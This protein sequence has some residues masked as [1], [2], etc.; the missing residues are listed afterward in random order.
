MGQSILETEPPK[1]DRRV[2]YG[3]GA[4]HFAD[5]R[6][7]AGPKP[8]PVV[9]NIHGG[10]WRARYDLTHAGHFCAALTT[11]GIATCNLEYRR[12]GNPG[13]GW[14]GTLDDI[15]AAYRYL[16]KNADRFGFDRD[17]IVV[18]GHSAGGHLALCLAGY[19]PEVRSVL[20]LAGV[21]DLKRAYELHL[22]NDAVL[23]FLGGTPSQVPES[24]WKA[25]AMNLKVNARQVIVTGSADESVPPELSR[26]Y[27]DMKRSCGE[28]VELIDIPQARHMDLINPESS[29]FP[30]VLRA[31]Q[32]LIS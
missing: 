16:S 1:P 9:V 8:W 19:E 6:F 32:S 18:S 28:A 30:V 7:P 4:L 3:T 17:R 24:Y 11:A 29:A 25:S 14:P 10:F 15:R 31:V 12:S 22:S 21:L 27:V 26:H 2:Y 20:S 23:E 13:G 5:L